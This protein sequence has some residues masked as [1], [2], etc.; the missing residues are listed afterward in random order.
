[1]PAKLATVH[2]RRLAN[3]NFQDLNPMC[4][5]AVL[6]ALDTEINGSRLGDV[7][8]ARVTTTDD[9]HRMCLLTPSVTADTVFG[10]IAVFREGDV[11]VAETDDEGQ[12]T[13][14]T[15]QLDDKEEAVL[16]SSY[17]LVHGPHVAI[18][19]Q[20]S[21]TRFVREYFNW[22]LRHPLGGLAPDEV[23]HLIP[24]AMADGKMV[25]LQEVK[26]LKIRGEIDHHHVAIA[27]DAVPERLG[28]FSRFI[29]RRL[30]NGAD[31]R[32][33]MRLFGLTD[34]SLHNVTDADLENLEFEL[35][36][37]K[38]EKRNLEVLPE[39]IIQG[40]LSDG[41]DTAAEFQTAG[42]RRRGNAIV[43]S[44]RGEVDLQGAYLELNSVRALLVSAIEEWGN[45]G[46]I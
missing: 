46:L 13:L 28:S 7:D 44:H 30:L 2:Y 33:L 34:G 43:M 25:G 4:R 11:P 39:S 36:V 16:G 40:L 20:E 37:K 31:G 9:G 5:D 23:V 42:T 24:M 38:R 6:T 10:E 14:K 41:V 18:L 32:D 3:R 26:S 15:I 35:V 29:E 45:Q 1:M 19:H 12:V 21:S 27:A 17:F 22:L 8:S